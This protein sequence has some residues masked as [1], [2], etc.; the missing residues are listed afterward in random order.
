[1]GMHTDRSTVA[2]THLLEVPAWQD[3]PAL[4]G[5][6]QRQRSCSGT[7]LP[8]RQVNTDFVVRMDAISAQ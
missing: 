4:R 3:V 2:R 1:M 7:S 6:A 5:S 8:V